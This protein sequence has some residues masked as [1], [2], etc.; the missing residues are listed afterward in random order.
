MERSKEGTSL[1]VL[2]EEQPRVVAAWEKRPQVATL[3]MEVEAAKKSMPY[4]VA[5]AMVPVSV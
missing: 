1:L 5:A 3:R 2:A 4:L